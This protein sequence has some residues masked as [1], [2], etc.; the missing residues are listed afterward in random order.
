MV[1]LKFLEI[2]KGLLAVGAGAQAYCASLQ[3]KAE[4]NGKSARKNSAHNYY[5]FV[6]KRKIFVESVHCCNSKKYDI[7]ILMLRFGGDHI[8][9]LY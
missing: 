7:F 2:L 1:N 8:E 9:N 3:E 5:N 6:R 4:T